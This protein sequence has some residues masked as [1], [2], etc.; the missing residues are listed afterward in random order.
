VTAISAGA[1]HTVALKNDGTVWAWGNN[2]NGQLGVGFTQI[3]SLINL[4]VPQ[5]TVTPS[6]GSGGNVNPPLAQSVTYNTTTSF[7]VTPSNGYEI[8]SV[9]GC[10]GSLSGNTYTTGPITTDCTVPA[11]FNVIPNVRISEAPLVYYGL[12]QP[13]YD[14]AATGAHIQAQGV[15][16]IGDL[17]MDKNKGV[18]INGGYD[19]TFTS[20]TGF[21]VLQGVLTLKAGSL[22]VDH[23]VI[24]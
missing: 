9:T 10:G 2:N 1:D 23:L 15:T 8:G 18:T 4:G 19:S 5:F 13:A 24:R 22:V 3:Q 16:L 12:L 7:S 17:T 14:A 21:T 11:T 20:Q 6:A